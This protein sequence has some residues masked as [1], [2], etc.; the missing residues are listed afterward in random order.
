M[1][2]VYVYVI[3]MSIYV[4]CMSIY[5][6]MNKYITYIHIC[7]YIYTYMCIYIYIER[8]RDMVYSDSRIPGGRPQCQ[9]GR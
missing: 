7:I 5:N 8:E 9:G 6:S 2:Y 1:L 3:C 4:I